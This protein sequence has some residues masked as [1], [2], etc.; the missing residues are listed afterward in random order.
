MQSTAR[1][2]ITGASGF[3]GQH[4]LAAFAEKFVG[5]EL[6][7]LD[8]AGEASTRLDMTDEESVE[9][10]IAFHRPTHLVHL[11]AISSV[12]QSFSNPALTWRTNVFG[13]LGLIIALQKH[14]PDCRMLFVSSAEVYGRSAFS[15]DPVTEGAL[16][17]PNNPYA[18]SKA[19]ADIMVREASNRGLKATIVRPFNHTGPGQGDAFVIPAFC[20]QIA[21]IEKGLQPPQMDVGELN[22][23]RDICD[24]RDIVDLYAKILDASESLP[25]GLTLNAASGVPRRIGDILETLLS[26][27]RIHIAVSQD[28]SRMR[29]VRVPRILGNADLARETLG[30]API[31]PFEQTL[32][33]TLEYWR[34]LSMG[35]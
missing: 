12:A 23:E 24:V 21:R 35:A 4:L 5:S 6:I 8:R 9:A 2:L 28:P 29:A 27:A 10:A 30:W 32:E 11:A 31:I 17:Q 14:V 20:S 22:D 18:A 26:K 15:S 7:A 33:E 16:L 34:S 3:V 1:I 19:A 25:P 13:T